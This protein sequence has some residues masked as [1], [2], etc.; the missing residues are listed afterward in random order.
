LQRG[1]TSASVALQIA[2]RADTRG[3]LVEQP[4][5]RCEH[6]LAV[7]SF[8]AQGGRHP[9]AGAGQCLCQREGTGEL[10]AVT[11]GTP[12]RVV[13]VLTSAGAV[14]ADGLDVSVRFGADP[15][16]LPRR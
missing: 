13:Q 12:L 16:V 14:R 1:E 9:S 8:A 15:D 5:R 10:A 3:R 11:A 6:A 2:R 4:E 7:E